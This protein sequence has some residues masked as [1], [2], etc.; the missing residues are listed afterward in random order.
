MRQP[1]NNIPA[2][3][4]ALTQWQQRS[5]KGC[6]GCECDSC[7]VRSLWKIW[8]HYGSFLISTSSRKF[9]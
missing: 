3:A 2:M 6:T 9:K 5:H 8:T 1:L 4:T 7:M